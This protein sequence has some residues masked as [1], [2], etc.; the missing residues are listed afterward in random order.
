MDLQLIKT[1]LVLLLAPHAE[2]NL[3]GRKVAVFG[4]GD[5]EGYGDYFCDAMEELY[6]AFTA[7]GAD[8]VGTWPTEG[9]VHSESKVRSKGN[10]V[11]LVRVH[12]GYEGRLS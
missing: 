8:M 9:Y 10:R 7:A 5:Q 6:S 3:K 12:A 1:S 2:L 4:C 11:F